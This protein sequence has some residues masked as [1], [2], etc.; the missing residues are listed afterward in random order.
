MD[1]QQQVVIPNAQQNNDNAQQYNGNAQQNNVVNRIQVR[2]PPFWKQNPQLWFRQLEAQFANSNIINDLTKF[3]TIVGVI[4]SDILSTVSDIVLDPPA[5]NMYNTIKQRLIQQYAE[6]DTKKIRNLLTEITLGDRKP[7]DLL[8]KM[9]ELSCN[10]VGDDLLKELWLQRLPVNIQIVLSASN[11]DLD[12]LVVMADSMVEIAEAA[13]IQAVSSNQSNQ[14]ND[15]VNAVYELDGKIENLKKGF[16][17]PG[18]RSKHASRHRSPTPSQAS[19]VQNK[20][21][22]YYHKKFDKQAVKC[23][24]PCSFNNSKN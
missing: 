24:K 12:Q 10:K 4:E 16:R 13:T 8:R 21:L 3:N 23:K 2:V 6:T 22:C 17:K 15:L 1:D 7:S 19:S 5:V 18:I 14:I 20:G 11:D 9:K